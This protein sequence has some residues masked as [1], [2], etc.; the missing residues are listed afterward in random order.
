M[1][2][3]ASWDPLTGEPGAF[4][5]I[6]TKSVPTYADP[7]EPPAQSFTT[8]LGDLAPGYYRVTFIDAA[9]NKELT[10]P[11]LFGGPDVRPSTADVAAHIRN[12]T[13]DSN[14]NFF[15]DFTDDSAVSLQVVEGLIVKAENRVLSRLDVDPNQILPTES[16]QIVKDLIALYAAMLVEITKFSEQIAADRSAYPYLKILFDEMMSQ[17]MQDIRGIITTSAG[18]RMMG[19]YDLVAVEEMTASFDFP[20]DPMV[21]WGTLF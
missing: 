18:T 13:V 8:E 10:A 9:G 21:N 17:A 12:R 3:E 15:D 1:I 4:A 5:L 6:D 16:L 20:N 2:E 19:L 7:E 14:N 11:V